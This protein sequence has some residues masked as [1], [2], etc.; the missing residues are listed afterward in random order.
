MSSTQPWNVVTST[1]LLE[2][3]LPGIIA[4]ANHLATSQEEAIVEVRNVLWKRNPC[5]PFHVTLSRYLKQLQKFTNH[6]SLGSREQNSPILLAALLDVLDTL[7][8]HFIMA[9]EDPAEPVAENPFIFRAI[10]SWLWRWYGLRSRLY[11]NLLSWTVSDPHD[12]HVQLLRLMRESRFQC[13]T[14]GEEEKLLQVVQNCAQEVNKYITIDISPEE[15]DDEAS[16][17]SSQYTTWGKIERLCQ[18]MVAVHRQLSKPWG[19]GCP[20]HDT[21]LYLAL[22]SYELLPRNE[23]F[24]VSSVLHDT[25]GWKETKMRMRCSQ[26]ENELADYGQL[27]DDLEVSGV[28]RLWYTVT[29]CDPCEQPKSFEQL[30]ATMMKPLPKERLC[31]AVFLSHLYLHLSGSDWWPYTQTRQPCRVHGSRNMPHL[32]VSSPYFAFARG[33]NNVDSTEFTAVLIN[34]GM[35]SLPEFGKL[36]LEVLTWTPCVWKA[37]KASEPWK[38]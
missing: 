36:I 1:Q 17:S 9:Q 18:S 16:I 32:P 6:L 19:C 11:K 35:P 3:L 23:T 2:T 8:D 4:V 22:N 25:R 15:E 27:C 26:N 38:L 5:R 14:F 33:T 20:K 34:P 7:E 21:T 28:E 37:N 30:Q 12:G 31:L 24:A 13:P 29:R 10:S